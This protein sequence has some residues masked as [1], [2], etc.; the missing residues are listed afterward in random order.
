MKNST[1]E[2]YRPSTRENYRPSISQPMGQGTRALQL[3]F[4]IVFDSPLV[5]LCESPSNYDKEPEGG[6]IIVETPST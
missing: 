2:N 6:D 1:R 4:Y 5:M 3:A